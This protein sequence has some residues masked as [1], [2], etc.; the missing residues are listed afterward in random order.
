[1]L[2]WTFNHENDIDSSFMYIPDI[3]S[4]QQISY[5]K[6][7]LNSQH[8]YKGYTKKGK[9]IDRL[10]KWFHKDCQYF[11][12]YW[13]TRFD[14]WKGHPYDQ[15]L[16]Y[17]QGM[18]LQKVQPY[19][20]D[21]PNIVGINSCLVNLYKDGKDRILP[22]R[23]SHLSFG[24]YPL[25]IGLSVG[26]TRTLVVKNVDTDKVELSLQ[27]HDNSVFIMSGS[28]QKYFTHEIPEDSKCVNKRW[29]LTFRKH[30]IK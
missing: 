14:R 12:E 19:L 11:C 4:K 23:D 9:Q 29:S 1:M 3:L 28:S 22:H 18:V 16:N 20:K 26:S 8:L 6:T 24:E 27:L 5:L 2:S 15:V 21:D 30:V 25:I 17:I 13:K 10:Q 7:W